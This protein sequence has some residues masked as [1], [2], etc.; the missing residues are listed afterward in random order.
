MCT[1]A[2][3]MGSVRPCRLARF[4]H[5][6]PVPCPSGPGCRQ[7]PSAV[8]LVVVEV[9]ALARGLPEATVTRGAEPTLGLAAH[10]HEAVARNPVVAELGARADADT[11]YVAVVRGSTRLVAI[12]VR[13][14]LVAEDRVRPRAARGRLAAL[15]RRGLGICLARVSAHCA[16]ELRILSTRNGRANETLQ[17]CSPDDPGSSERLARRSHGEAAAEAGGLSA[18]GPRCKMPWAKMA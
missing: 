13:E 6:R 2:L 17:Q 10:V 3:Q 4:W 8:L 18:G 16:A 12:P 14:H 15:L 11:A 9:G 7:S 5:Q 1:H